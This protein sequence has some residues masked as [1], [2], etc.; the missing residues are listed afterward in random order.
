MKANQKPG[1]GLSESVTIV[2]VGPRD[3]L[4]QE[5]VIFPTAEKVR[6]IEGLIA[7]GIKHIQV[8][9][10]VRPDVIPQLADAER[11]C[12]LIPRPPD[13]VYSGL[14]LNKMGVRRARD[15]GLAWVDLSVSASDAHSRRNVNRTREEALAEFQEMV[16]TAR[17][18]GM[19]VRGG[20]MC[21]FG[22]RQAGDV[23]PEMV[24]SL[25]RRILETGVNEFVLADSA[26]L[27]DPRAIAL[28]MAEVIPFAGETPIGL[29][30]HDTRGMGLANVLAGLQAGVRAFD[31]AFGGLGGC[32]FIEGAAGNIASE[33][34][35][36]MLERMGFSTG[37]DLRL[38]GQVSDWFSR[39]LGRP[40][41][42]RIYKLQAAS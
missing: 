4:Q 27:A 13:V 10:F 21:A 12:A 30:L 39:R 26:G 5:S 15:A 11:L 6:L 7:A 16:A 14:A 1:A 23:T 8:T 25:A 22:Y 9:S 18:S 3:G 35:A 29:H 34:T 41:P 37:I 40:L 20:I 36:H 38:L 17:S 31:A 33:D 2:E 19:F 24:I 32:P 42:G 28:M